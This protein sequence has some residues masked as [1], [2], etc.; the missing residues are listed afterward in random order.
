[1]TTLANTSALAQTQH[2][3]KIQAML[4]SSLLA[5]LELTAKMPEQMQHSYARVLNPVSKQLAD[6]MKRIYEAKESI[7]AQVPDREELLH[8]RPGLDNSAESCR[9]PSPR[10]T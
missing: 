8:W 1:M 6:Q 3:M 9:Q 5:N 4:P 10:R 7:R 2:V